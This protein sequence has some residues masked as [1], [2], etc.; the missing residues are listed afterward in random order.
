MSDWKAVYG[1]DFAVKGLDL[2][3]GAQVDEREWFAEPLREAYAQG[4]FPKERLSDM[5]RRIL[6]AIYLVEAD[7][8]KGPQPQPD[9]QAHLNSAI[10]VARQG[11][12][13][14]K[15][16][17]MLPIPSDGKTMAIIALR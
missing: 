15:N 2:H 12:V 13:L 16:D 17:G 9:L 1:W 14:L 10:E 5:V 7:R 8:W 3:S 4:R 11:T 6:Y